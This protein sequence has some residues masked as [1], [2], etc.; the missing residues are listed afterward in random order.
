V[1]NSIDLPGAAP[2]GRTPHDAHDV[3]ALTPHAQ[4]VRLSLGVDLCGLPVPVLVTD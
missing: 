4:A 2:P 3:D 1:G